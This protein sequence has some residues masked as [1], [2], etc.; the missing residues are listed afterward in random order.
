MLLMFNLDYTALSHS[1]C[2]FLKILLKVLHN[3]LGH[4]SEYD[5]GVSRPRVSFFEG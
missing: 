4:S 5:Y 2:I 3:L 1:L